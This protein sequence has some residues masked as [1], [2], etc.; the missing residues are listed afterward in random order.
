VGAGLRGR[1]PQTPSLG[2]YAPAPTPNAA[3]PLPHS[4]HP[5]VEGKPDRLEVRFA[6]LRLEPAA[7]ASEAD[8]RK[9]LGALA[10]ANPGMDRASGVLEVATPEGALPAGWMDYHAMTQRW[11]LV[12]GNAGSTTLLRRKA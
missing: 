8:L 4:P 7:G 6:A 2:P 3:P 5:A 11:Q 1:T 10:E 9:W 12:T